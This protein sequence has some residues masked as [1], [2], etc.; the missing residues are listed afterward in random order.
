MSPQA[1]KKISRDMNSCLEA[2]KFPVIIDLGSE[3]L[4]NLITMHIEREAKKKKPFPYVN[5]KHQELK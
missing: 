1:L 4:R 2:E 5:G 3:R